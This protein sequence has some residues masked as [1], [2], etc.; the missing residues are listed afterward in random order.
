[1]T[2]R[3]LRFVA[4]L[5][6]AVLIASP[7]RAR[8]QAYDYLVYD[9]SNW[10]QAVLQFFQMLEQARIL[11]R[12]ARRLPLDMVTRY[13]GTSVD[14][15][16]HSI[17]ARLQYAQR[18]LGALNTGDR[19][20]TAYRQ[21]GNRYVGS[22]LRGKCTMQLV[23]RLATRRVTGRQRYGDH[24][25][26]ICPHATGT[27]HLVYDVGL[28]YPVTSGLQERA[29]NLFR[30]G[31]R[32]APG[33]ASPPVD[34]GTGR[35]SGEYET[36]AQKRTRT[37]TVLPPLGPEPSASTNFAIWAAARIIAAKADLRQ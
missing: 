23:V 4:A 2:R 33:S 34:A 1:M 12:Q 22:C 25:V 37:S 6:V 11:A 29:E 24:A 27:A 5:L 3:P 9:D 26:R 18:I 21:R 7:V 8:A 15:S 10:Y 28:A 14:W 36:G 13:R 16:L 20:G 31:E 17:D 32:P 30:C 19:T 35:E